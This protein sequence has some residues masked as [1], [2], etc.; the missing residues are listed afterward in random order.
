MK[1]FAR[2]RN[3]MCSIRDEG[4]AEMR[5]REKAA[6]VAALMIILAGG[7]TH[8]GFAETTTVR[9]GLMVAGIVEW[10]DG[11]LLTV[12]G[13]TFD[14]KGVPVRFSEG[15]TQVEKPFLR[16]KLVQILIYN[17]KIHSVLVLNRSAQ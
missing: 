17:R 1:T 9:G 5:N 2:E 14:T 3:R 4:G 10:V 16:G 8:P 11:D 6:V 12:D 15:V 7:W 13:K